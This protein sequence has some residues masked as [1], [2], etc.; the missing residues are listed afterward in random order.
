MA[1]FME[2]E[3]QQKTSS[4]IFVVSIGVLI[5]LLVLGVYWLLGS[6]NWRRMVPS[7]YVI[8]NIEYIGLYNHIGRNAYLGSSVSTSVATVLEYWNPGENNF[9]AIRRTL[10]T[11][12]NRTGGASLLKSIENLGDYEVYGESL[13][14]RELGKYLNEKTRTPLLLYLP[15]DQDAPV[16]DTFAERKVSHMMLLIGKNDEE[17]QLTFHDYW[18]GSN[19]V[20]SYEE[21][22]RLQDLERPNQR[23]YYIVVRPNDLS[24][25]LADVRSRQIA[26]YPARTKVMEQMVPLMNE[27]GVGYAYLLRGQYALSLEHFLNAER[28]TE[29][30]TFAPPFVQ[31]K[32][33]YY[34]GLAYLN[35][36]DL[37]KALEYAQRAISV[38]KGI[39]EPFLDWPGYQFTMNRPSSYGVDSLPYVLAGDIYVQLNRISDARDAYTK[40]LEIYPK[41]S[42]ISERIMSLNSIN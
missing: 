14:I 41:N 7:S 8:P 21:F 42:L 1:F 23:N 33:Y 20:L 24:A 34:M 39:D 25:A 17:K 6:E 12:E 37:D 10:D 13:E 3:G 36:K 32:L 2:Q 35:Q 18:F 11:P 30:S 22:D 26:A 29:L 19:Y 40:A 9:D 38:N 16:G 27:Y 28:T 15:F 5:V 4:N 31:T